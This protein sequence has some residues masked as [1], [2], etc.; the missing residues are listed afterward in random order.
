M[1]SRWGILVH[2]SMGR[3]DG[4]HLLRP[5]EGRNTFGEGKVSLLFSEAKNPGRTE[6]LR[7]LETL[8]CRAKRSLR[9]S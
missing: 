6:L 9:G 5:Y 3:W 4:Q 1:A 8:R 2:W 7:R